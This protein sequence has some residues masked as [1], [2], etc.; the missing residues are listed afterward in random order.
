MSLA[1][2][3]LEKFPIGSVLV[4]TTELDPWAMRT[5]H[6]PQSRAKAGDVEW[7]HHLSHRN[8]LIKKINAAGRSSSLEPEQRFRVKYIRDDGWRVAALHKSLHDDFR[9]MPDKVETRARR[10]IEMLRND[11]DAI[12]HSVLTAQQAAQLE[13]MKDEIDYMH[14]DI[15]QGL[16][17]V[18]ARRAKILGT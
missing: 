7:E 5:G 16:A 15:E 6:L 9:T 10:I 2:Q 12:G 3:F 18:K 11:A 17:K 1:L 14:G 4:A 13:R 8:A